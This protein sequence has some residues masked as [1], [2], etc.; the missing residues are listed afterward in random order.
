MK[1]NFSLSESKVKELLTPVLQ[2]GIA[3]NNGTVGDINVEKEYTYNS[4]NNPNVA[5][6]NKI[7]LIKLIRQVATDINNNK[8][9]LG[10]VGIVGNEC[11][12]I[13]L[14]VAKNYIEKYFNM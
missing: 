2:E 7:A 1:I 14:A 8:V 10:T 5:R 6:A 4:L 9:E 3:F 11:K 13:P 12:T